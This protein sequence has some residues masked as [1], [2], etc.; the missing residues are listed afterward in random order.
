MLKAVRC[1]FHPQQEILG[2]NTMATTTFDSTHLKN[3]SLKPIGQTWSYL[4]CRIGHLF[5]IWQTAIGSSFRYG[6]RWRDGKGIAVS[7]RQLP[8]G[9]YSVLQHLAGSIMTSHFTLDCSPDLVG[10]WHPA[11]LAPCPSMQN[12]TFGPYLASNRACT[13]LSIVRNEE[14][15]TCQRSGGA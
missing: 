6:N 3:P 5:P 15:R 1:L 9:A 8:H 13:M 11:V 2:P 14:P 4:A 7:W 10:D 12:R